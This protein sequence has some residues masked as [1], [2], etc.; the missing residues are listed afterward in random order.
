MSLRVKTVEV[1][2]RSFV[3]PKK[4]RELNQYFKKHG[5]LVEANFDQTVYFDAPK[6][7][8]TRLDKNSAFLILKEGRIHDEGREEIEIALPKKSFADLE[9]LLERLGFKVKIRWYR[10]RRVYQWRGVRVYLGITLGYGQVIELEKMVTLEGKDK[11]HQRLTKMLEGLKVDITPKEEFE[12]RF[13]HYAQNW[14]SLIRQSW[15]TSSKI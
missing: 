3:T 8:R 9:N 15:P 10:K 14:P 1:E 12:K 2:A 7:L 13:A 11:V 6:D 4:W 5:R